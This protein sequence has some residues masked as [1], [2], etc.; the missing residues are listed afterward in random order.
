MPKNTPIDVTTVSHAITKDIEYFQKNLSRPASRQFVN[1][2]WEKPS[3]ESPSIYT[4]N[5]S[6]VDNMKHQN[7]LEL[8]MT[9][10]GYPHVV[11]QSEWETDPNGPP[12]MR[13]YPQKRRTVVLS[14]MTQ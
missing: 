13:S 1:Y 5:K 11:K 8:M 9:H 12:D 14:S 6:Q 4:Q 7:T 3:D 10:Q 2:T